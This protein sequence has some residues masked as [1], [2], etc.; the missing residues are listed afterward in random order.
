MVCLLHT[1]RGKSMN[2][3]NV[4][5]WLVMVSVIRATRIVLSL[6]RNFDCL[7]WFADTIQFFPIGVCYVQ[8]L[9]ATFRK[10]SIMASTWL[11]LVS[12][13]FAISFIALMSWVWVEWSWQK[14]CCLSK[15]MLCSSR[16]GI[17]CVKLMCSKILLFKNWLY[18]TQTSI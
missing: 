7:W 14:P 17:M 1:Q 9:S 11:S 4:V 15:K 16:C 12:I 5:M 3:I 10:S 13:V 18:Y 8:L 2:F 6:C